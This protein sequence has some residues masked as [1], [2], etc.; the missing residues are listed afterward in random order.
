MI[1]VCEDRLLGAAASM[2]PPLVDSFGRTHTYLRISVTDRCNLRCFYCMP[3]EGIQPCSR[4]DI[5]TY[6][7]IA[8]LTAL[9]A[10]MGIRKIRLTG[11]EPLVRRDLALLVESLAQ[12][13]QI[14]TVALTTNGILLREQ[15]RDL[16]K[17]GL[18]S[19]NISLDT[20]KRERFQSIARRDH[21][22][23]VL[24]GIDAACEA[25][26]SSVKLNVVVMRGVN[27]DELIDFIEFALARNLVIRFIEHMPFRSNSWRPEQ[28]ISCEEMRQVIAARYPL[29]PGENSGEESVAS[30][31]NVPNHPIRIGFI[32]SL[33][34]QFC[35]QCN[36]LR[37]LSDGSLKSCLFKSPEINLRD[38]LRQGL[39]G[40]SLA[41]LIRS[42][43]LEKPPEH[44]SLPDLLR[45]G[46]EN[47][48]QI[49]G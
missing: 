3:A 23:R 6:E 48:I 38:A 8:R 1:S 44:P 32:S 33:S 34:C 31:Y 22:E 42:A 37:L 28:F 10:E 45:S 27:D 14:E 47:M 13:P 39:A 30:Y 49:G 20:L 19:I 43:L 16:R 26:F 9:F 24:A 2:R 5:L 11:G 36:R 40:E 41:L 18:H 46:D 35:G 21:L 7:E 29:V 12:I 15:A 25:L 4:D 17:A